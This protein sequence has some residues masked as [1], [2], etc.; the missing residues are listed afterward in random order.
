MFG[1]QRRVHLPSDPHFSVALQL[2]ATRSIRNR[3]YL[4]E[5]TPHPK[6]LSATK[7]ALFTPRFCRCTRKDTENRQNCATRYTSRPEFAVTY[8]KHRHVKFLPETLPSVFAIR[9]GH[10]RKEPAGSPRYEIRSRLGFVGAVKSSALRILIVN[11][12]I[13]IH[14][15]SFALSTNSISNRQ[16]SRGAGNLSITLGAPIFSRLGARFALPRFTDHRSRVTSLLID[17]MIIR[18]G[19]KSFALNANSISNRQYPRA[20]RKPPISLPARRRTPGCAPVT[21]NHKPTRCLLGA[22]PAVAG[23]EGGAG[24]ELRITSHDSQN[25]CFFFASLLCCASQMGERRYVIF[26]TIAAP[27]T[28]RVHEDTKRYEV[29]NG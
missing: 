1:V 2:S 10:K 8:R 19:P 14:P 27:H 28:P 23:G 11:M 20:S 3:A 12:I 15:K 5:N 18:I 29:P 16:Y 22:L 9:V 4:S 25:L 6:T 17:N 26:D 7:S 21:T 13:R 24:H